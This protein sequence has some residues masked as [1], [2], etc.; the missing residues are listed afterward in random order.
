MYLTRKIKL[1][2]DLRPELD[3][4]RL[5]SGQVWSDLVTNFWRV[6][7]KKDIWL[8]QYT[9]SRWIC[10]TD[11][12]E[13]ISA[14]SIQ[15]VNTQ[16]FDAFASW[17]QHRKSDH[18]AR[19]PRK[20]KKWNKVVWNSQGM[21]LKDGV[22]RLSRGRGVEA[23]GVKWEHDVVPRQAELLYYDNQYYLHCQYKVEPQKVVTGN[24]FAGIDLGEIHLAGV[25][26]GTKTFLFNGRELRA[27]RRYQNKLKGKLQ[28]LISRTKPCSRRRQVLVH[29][30]NKQLKAL[31]NQIDDILHKTSRKLVD[32]LLKRGVSTLVIGDLNGIRQRINYGKKTNQK[33]HQ[34]CFSRFRRMIEYKARLL[35]MEVVLINEAYTSQTCPACGT[36][37][38]PKGRTYQCKSCGLEAHRDAVGAINIRKKYLD[39][40]G[41]VK[42]PNERN[43]S[44]VVGARVSPIGI[45][46]KTGS[47]CSS[48]HRRV[49]S[50]EVV[51]V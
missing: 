42:N 25:D 21:R 44:P 48:F 36:R 11:R 26:D 38:K 22:L 41:I 46:Y 3:V 4:M 14:Q 30:K 43:S 17:R 20:R 51:D 6:V 32:T 1:D 2:M 45:R 33:L 35:G 28:K 31:K 23:L 18:K 7:R 27:K 49:T 10:K 39:K 5:A 47:G 15:G 16:L 19:P 13:G 8:S 24:K 40:L 50:L 34:W 37:K 12:Y 29:S 9:L